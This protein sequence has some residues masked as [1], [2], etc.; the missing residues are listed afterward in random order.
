MGHR[1]SAVDARADVALGVL[2]MLAGSLLDGCAPDPLEVACG[3][4]RPSLDG[5]TSVGV[6]RADCGGAREPVFAC[7]E[8]TGACRWFAGACVAAGHQPSDCP[9]EDRCCHTNAAGRWPFADGW[10]PAMLGPNVVEDIAIVGGTPID[11]TSPTPITVR[12]DPTLRPTP[13][14]TCTG[15]FWAHGADL[16]SGF[17]GRSLRPGRDPG[18]FVLWVLP[19]LFGSTVQIELLTRPDGSLV[20]RAFIGY[21]TDGSF[22][23]WPPACIE[24]IGR[25]I[26]SAGTLTMNRLDD[27]EPVHLVLTLE[28]GDGSLAIAL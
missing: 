3:R 11:A 18:T 23:G 7:D 25:G 13:S 1:S 10:R 5:C 16:C 19:N 22:G 9:P 6:Y 8:T 17:V 15:P 20:G 12:V 14:A 2:A 21:R 4:A 28:V 26:A 24:P 27:R